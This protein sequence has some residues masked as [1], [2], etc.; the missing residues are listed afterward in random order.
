MP[1]SKSLADLLKKL[2]ENHLSILKIK[3]KYE[4]KS[5]PT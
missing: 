1:E 2:Y 3:E 4:T 5:I